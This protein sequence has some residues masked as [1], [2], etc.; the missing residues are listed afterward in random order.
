MFSSAS[1]QVMN[2]TGQDDRSW[3][4]GFSKEKLVDLL[5]LQIRNIWRVDGLYFLG[6]EEKFGTEA[7]TTIDRNCWSILARLEARALKELLELKSNDI[8]A[9]V[10]ALRATSWALYQEGKEW[11]VKAGKA[12]LRITSC[13]TQKARIRKGL[14]EFPCKQV[15]WTYLKEFAKEFNP[16]IEVNC[17]VCPPDK[18]D[19][20]LWCEWEFVLKSK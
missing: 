2:L 11:E 1:L 20:N 4:L 5:F 18:H 10:T 8:E 14:G 12:I 6:I 17:I 19:E 3:L 13:R 9:F 15:R 16:E 7:A